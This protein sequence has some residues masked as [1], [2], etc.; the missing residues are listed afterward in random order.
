M[1]VFDK[2]WCRARVW[3]MVEGKGV[4]GR[5]LFV[6]TATV[7]ALS[8]VPSSSNTRAR[9]RCNNY[10]ILNAAIVLSTRMSKRERQNKS[11][12]QGLRSAAI[13][14]ESL[15]QL[16]L[17]RLG[18]N[19]FKMHSFFTQRSNTTSWK[20][21][22]KSNEPFEDM[23]HVTDLSADSGRNIRQTTIHFRPT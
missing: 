23:I 22:R 4:T 5:R 14:T 19:K 1:V 12:I 2:G 18:T 3:S 6:D 20:I 11:K 17:V 9:Y 7:S 13:G 15:H 8:L 10:P 16:P 21:E